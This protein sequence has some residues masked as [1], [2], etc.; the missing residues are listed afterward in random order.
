MTIIIG[1]RRGAGKPTRLAT[2]CLSSL[3]IN[4][5]N[6]GDNNERYKNLICN[7]G[8]EAKINNRLKHVKSKA[9]E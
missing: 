8:D 6:E 5:C 3:S 7:N 2:G 9:K 1:G 4:V